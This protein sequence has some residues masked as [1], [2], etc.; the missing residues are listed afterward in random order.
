[1]GNALFEVSRRGA[2][3]GKRLSIA[4]FTGALGIGAANVAAFEATSAAA[5]IPTR[6]IKYMAFLPPHPPPRRVLGYANRAIFSDK[7]LLRCGILA[8]KPP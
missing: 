4:I 3:M 7:T 6:W 5:E 1:M 8:L 2:D